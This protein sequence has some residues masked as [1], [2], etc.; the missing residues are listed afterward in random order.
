M[1]DS[2]RSVEGQSSKMPV[3]KRSAD[4]SPD[5]SAEDPDLPAIK[6]ILQ[7]Y[8]TVFT[9]AAASIESPLIGKIQPLEPPTSREPQTYIL[10]PDRRFNGRFSIPNALSTDFPPE[11]V[12][13]DDLDKEMILKLQK[14]YTKMFLCDSA[15][16]ALEA[17]V[18][19]KLAELDA[20]VE[21]MMIIGGITANFGIAITTP[22]KSDVWEKKSKKHEMEILSTLCGDHSVFQVTSADGTAYI[23]DFTLE[24]FGHDVSEWFLPKTLYLERYVGERETRPVT[25]T[26][27]ENVKVADSDSPWLEAM[28]KFCEE[29][30]D[31]EQ[32]MAMEDDKRSEEVTKKVEA[33]ENL[34]T[35]CKQKKFSV[36]QSSNLVWGG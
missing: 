20:K 35:E 27:R 8:H 24:Q 19:Q 9:A 14:A 33:S 17:V 16:E 4:T 36:E 26:E 31:W 23:A 28:H 30:L 6:S 22:Q 18:G 5:I 1:P 13:S 15:L 12:G 10:I 32:L 7:V 34:M 11:I 21:W 29:E 3:R 2:R 25:E